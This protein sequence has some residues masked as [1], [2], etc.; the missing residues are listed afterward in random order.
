MTLPANQFLQNTTLLQSKLDDLE[1]RVAQLESVI[2]FIGAGGVIISSGVGG[3]HLE[4]Q[5]N[6]E[7]DAPRG[8]SIDSDAGVFIRSDVGHVT[9]NAQSYVKLY[10]YGQ[11]V[12]NKAATIDAGTSSF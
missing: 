2:Q 3:I 5:G 4:S 6:I 10:T 11:I 7:I 12:M 1:R 8:I 9:F